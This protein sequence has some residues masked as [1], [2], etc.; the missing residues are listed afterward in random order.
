MTS[1]TLDPRPDDAFA[2]NVFSV[3]SEDLDRI[4]ELYRA[5]FREVRQIVAASE[6]TDTVAL[7]AIQL[8]DWPTPPM[9]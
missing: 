1:R 2:Y 6:P 5:F 7:L 8:L 3:K 4:R 9:D